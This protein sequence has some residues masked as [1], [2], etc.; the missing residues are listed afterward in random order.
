[1]VQALSR[2]VAVCLL[3]GIAAVSAF[4]ATFALR[5]GLLMPIWPNTW[6]STGIASNRQRVS[7]P[8]IFGVTT[9]VLSVGGGV[10]LVVCLARA[11]YDALS[12]AST[13]AARDLEVCFWRHGHARSNDCSKSHQFQ[14]RPLPPADPTLA[15]A[16]SGFVD[17]PQPG[18]HCA[19]MV[20]ISERRFSRRNG[21]VFNYQ[22]AQSHGREARPCRRYHRS[23]FTRSSAGHDRSDRSLMGNCMHDRFGTKTVNREKMDAATAR[24]TIFPKYWYRSRDYVIAGTTGEPDHVLLRRYSVPRWPIWGS[25]GPDVLVYGPKEAPK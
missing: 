14:V 25:T 13:F 19:A 23:N 6:F 3:V 5:A 22:R 9:T 16:I 12:S 1:M 10:L 2:K 24:A 8:H 17:T 7:P 18:R 15:H 20:A 21:L 4:V 11:A